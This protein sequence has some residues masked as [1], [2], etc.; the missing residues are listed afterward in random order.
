MPT[1]PALWFTSRTPTDVGQR[2]CRF[3]RWMGYHAGP[4]GTGYRRRSLSVPLATGGAVHK[5]I[6]LLAQWITDYQETHRGIPPL[7]TTACP[8]GVPREVIAWAALEAA[9]IYEV[10]ARAKGFNE[11]SLESVGTDLPVG[12]L[13]PQVEAL[14]LEQ[15]TLIEAQVWIYGTLYMP[16]MLS[17]YRI[18]GCEVEETLVLDCTCGLGDG[19]GTYDVHEARGCG[20]IV[21]MGR[22]DVLWEGF[23]GDAA[24]LIVYDEAKTKASPNMPWEKAW[25]HSGQLLVNMETAARRLG[26][27]I[28]HASIVVLFKGW[29]GRDRNDPPEAPKY[30]HTPLVY[31]Y[32]DAG[33]AGFRDPAW[34][35][36]YKWTDDYGKGHTLPRTYTKTPIWRED[37]AL[38]VPDPRPGASRVETW[39]TQKIAATQWTD[40]LKVL[41]PFPH[42]VARVPLALQGILAEERDWREIAEIVRG[43]V[44]K[45]VPEHEIADQIIPRSWACTNYGGDPC[46]FKRICDRDP[47]WQDPLASGHYDIRR[48]HHATE[49]ASCERAGVVFPADEDEEYEEVDTA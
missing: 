36:V 48:P 22:A 11:S 29:R 46:A 45:G 32:Y 5:G 12:Q 9:A 15:R 14:I 25:E 13:P 37:I 39:V 42:P 17:Q 2:R 1:Y 19:F 43:E 16:Q 27:R 49:L 3:E 10:K 26:K 30:Q 38:D 20:G 47:G 40:L 21:Q 6:E 41:G 24:G 18:L 8:T 34:S 31:G 33:S 7:P 35:A 4:H 23:T 44:A 28:D